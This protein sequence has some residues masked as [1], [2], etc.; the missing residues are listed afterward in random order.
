MRP[1]ITIVILAGGAA[2]RLPGKLALPIGDEPMLVRVHRR[3][4]A[5]GRPCVVSARRPLPAELLGRIDAPVVYDA[6]GDA[7]PLAGLAV[8]AAAVRTELL[9]ACA[10]DLPNIDASL[11]D[12]LEREF[13]RLDA[14]GVAADAIVPTWPDGKAEPLA[15]LYV[16]RRLAAAAADALK[17][18]TRKVMAALDVFV[19]ARYALG[20][21]DGAMLANVNTPADYEATAG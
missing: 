12:Q 7:G 6:V 11:V 13:E 15:A 20:A 8:A 14:A 3:L 18:G 9:F 17:A 5:G 2:T 19:L 21:E 4:T 10:G 1:R 16:A